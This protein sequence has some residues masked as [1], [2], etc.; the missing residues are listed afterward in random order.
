V[1]QCPSG[2]GSYRHAGR[3]YGF[4]L[5]YDRGTTSARDYLRKFAAYYA[6]WSSGRYALDYDGFP[7]ILVVTSDNAAED[8]I[9]RAAVAAA[10]GR[11][12]TL[13]LLLTCRW[14]IDDAHNGSGLLGPI[15]RGLGSTERRC[16]PAPAPLANAPVDLAGGRGRTAPL[17][18]RP[19]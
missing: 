11:G 13:P 18:R 1:T 6:Y 10:V 3:P 8:R 4:F 5:E 16:W 9:A 14:R 7:T 12:P 17:G 15:W 2:Y 19:R